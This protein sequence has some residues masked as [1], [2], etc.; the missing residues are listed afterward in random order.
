MKKFIQ[1]IVTSLFFLFIFVVVLTLV[2][3]RIGLFGLHSYVVQTGSMEPTIHVASI[4]F[5]MPGTYNKGDIIT[6]NRDNKSITHR[7]IEHKNNTYIVKGDANKVP[8][9]QPVRNNDIVGKDLVII[10]IIGRFIGFVR[11]VPGFL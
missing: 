9:P 3:A 5:T 2:T 11:T 8:D 7:I 4:V 1:L 6:F 10:P